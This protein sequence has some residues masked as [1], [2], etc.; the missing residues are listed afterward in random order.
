MSIRALLLPLL[1][2]LLPLAA[3]GPVDEPTQAVA[4]VNGREISVHQFHHVTRL[5]GTA[6]ASEGQRREWA[7]KL[8]DRELAVQQALA[9]ELD[10]QPDV[11]LRLDEARRDVLARAYAERIAATRLP[12]TRADAS[13]FFADH[14][15][16]F[17]KRRIFHMHEVV[18]T[19]GS[20]EFAIA[21]QRLAESPSHDDLV[22]WLRHRNAAFSMQ[23]TI[24]AAEELPI[25]ALARLN[26]TTNGGTAIFESPRGISVYKV[27]SSQEAPVTLEQ[28][29]PS[30]MSHLARQ[31]GKQALETE[32]KRL[33]GTSTIEY[34]GEFARLLQPGTGS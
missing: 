30:I 22:G 9:E 17:A 12:P 25:E 28:S 27:V 18:V 2:M 33:R 13:R 32:M 15:E 3:C 21:K 26:A 7:G 16:L 31:D 34:Y 4:R 10:R 11:M 14:P 24:R 19:A 23:V 8:V 5:A 1:S 29:M 20:P 6:A